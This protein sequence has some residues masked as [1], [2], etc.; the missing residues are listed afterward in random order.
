[1]V[2]KWLRIKYKSLFFSTLFIVLIM[3]MMQNSGFFGDSESRKARYFIYLSEVTM[4]FALAA[5]NHNYGK[6]S[7]FKNR[8]ALI[9]IA[10]IVA[11]T[12]LSPHNPD[13]GNIIKFLGYFICFDFGRNIAIISPDLTKIKIQE[14]LL[15]S[16]PLLA[17][18]L[19]DNTPYR[20]MFFSQSNSFTY[21]GLS[22]IFLFYISHRNQ[23]PLKY[24]R[25]CVILLL[26]YIFS[27]TSF[28]ILIG[29][30]IALTYVYRN[31][32]NFRKWLI[33][34]SIVMLLCI[35]FSS[36]ALFVRIRDLLKFI[37]MENMRILF[38]PETIDQ[39]AVNHSE[40]FESE[41]HDVTSVLWRILYWKTILI[42]YIRHLPWS[43]LGLGD[44]CFRNLFYYQPHNEFIR[45][46]F[47]FGIIPF[48]IIIGWISKLWKL[49]RN[50]RYSFFVIIIGFIYM[51]HNPL[52]QFVPNAII[53]F[54]FGYLSI[55]LN[56]K[57]STTI[58]SRYGN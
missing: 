14:R 13:F 46:L 12:V 27:G 10:C 2:S 15:V 33:L 53:Y 52:E 37:Q 50:T 39:T 44:N 18:A 40:M 43:L 21:M 36:V 57:T 20:S 31:N 42:Y 54:C 17:V 51:T 56:T 58:S 32:T 26:A 38:S 55:I 34:I 23:N 22:A 45:I 29:F 11:N 16:L 47:E 5:F 1:M 30:I 35:E 6:A 7:I 24:F 9:L 48:G 49:V 28:S 41:R 25:V 8:K 4:L 19:F 3:S